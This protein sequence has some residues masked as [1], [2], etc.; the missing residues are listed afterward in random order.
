MRRTILLDGDLY[1][2]K[3]CAALERP[4]QFSESLT[5]LTGNPSE[6]FASFKVQVS[7]FMDACKADE[8]IICFSSPTRRYFRHTVLPTYKQNRTGT[9]KPL[10]LPAVVELIHSEYRTYAKDD[11]EGDDVMGILAT[12]KNIVKGQKIIVSGDK[13]MKSIPGLLYRDGKEIEIDEETANIAHMYQTLVGDATDGYSGCNGVGPVGAKKIL[14]S[15]VTYAALWPKVVQAFIKAGFGEEWATTQAR[16]ARI[17]RTEDYN[18]KLKQ[19]ILWRPPI[20]DG[21]QSND[22][23]HD[24]KRE[25]EANRGADGGAGSEHSEC[26]SGAASP[27]G[28]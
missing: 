13:D 4:L 18:F 24:I 26:I 25:P 2:F 23:E 19:P 22:G 17:L 3:T 20:N 12:N 7:R 27:E 10:T 8:A 14:G 15:D 21:E 11:L 5:V 6:A 9:R 16:V 1:A 28:R